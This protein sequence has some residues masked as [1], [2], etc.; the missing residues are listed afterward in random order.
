[1]KKCIRRG[2]WTTEEEMYANRLIHE[3]KLGLLPLTDGTTLRNFLSKLLNCDPMRISKKFVGNK[4]IGK[5]IFRR[6][7]SDFEKL[8]LEQMER[9]RRDISEL[10]RRFLEKVAQGNRANGREGR[11]SPA[12]PEDLDGRSTPPWMA[13]SA[14]DGQVD[15]GVAEDENHDYR[16]TFNEGT[17]NDSTFHDYGGPSDFV[18]ESNELH[19][20][21]SSS[22]C[23]KRECASAGSSKSSTPP[24]LG[25]SAPVSSFSAPFPSALQPSASTDCFF[26]IGGGFKSNQDLASLNRNTSVENFLMLVD[27]GCLPTP[28]T[29]LLSTQWGSYNSSANPSSSNLSALAAGLQRVASKNSLSN[30]V[31]KAAY[32]SSQ[33]DKRLQM[34]NEKRLELAH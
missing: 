20:P 17:F 9:T 26:R 2:K 29:D 34:F 14:A 16:N 10:E 13:P 1:M 33:Y 24:P 21:S 6:R 22:L 5:Q 28:D 18:G 3:F 32:V 30:D 27:S 25:Q 8:S 31:N 23:V 4:C 19:A 15:N 12:F 11:Q 7:Q